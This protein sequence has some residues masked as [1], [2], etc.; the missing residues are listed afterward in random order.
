MGYNPA[1]Q[2]ESPLPI[3]A[4]WSTPADLDNGFVAPDAFGTADGTLS[5]PPSPS[6]YFLSTPLTK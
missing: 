3:L 6:I 1:D 2:Y 4:A 5:S